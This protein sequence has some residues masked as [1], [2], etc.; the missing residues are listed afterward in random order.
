MESALPTPPMRIHRRDG[1]NRH[2]ILD[3]IARLQHVHRRAHAQVVVCDFELYSAFP[4]LL[5][6]LK[7]RE[8]SLLFQPVRA[9]A[10]H[11]RKMQLAELRHL[12]VLGLNRA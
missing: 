6:Y 4:F 9:L 11:G 1:R 5:N 8:S 10:S 3:I 12:N 2:D 7:I